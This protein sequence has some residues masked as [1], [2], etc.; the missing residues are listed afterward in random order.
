MFCSDLS[1]EFWTGIAVGSL[2]MADRLWLVR[3]RNE[4][5]GHMYDMCM[6]YREDVMSELNNTGTKL[7]DTP[8]YALR[9]YQVPSS[10]ETLLCYG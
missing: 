6:R 4:M 5:S 9:L 7:L 3:R 2:L 10:A 8:S 1:A